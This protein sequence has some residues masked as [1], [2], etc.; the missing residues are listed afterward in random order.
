MIEDPYKNIKYFNLEN[1]MKVYILPDKKATN[2]KI[3]IE[4]K[5]G[6][7]IENKQNAG[8][9]HIVEHLMFRDKN[10]PHEDYLDYIK[11]EGG[12]DVNAY[13]S[14]FKTTYFATIKSN[15]TD[16]LV[17]TF[18][19]MLFIKN[20]R[21]KDLEIEKRALQAE[22]GELEWYD[23]IFYYLSKIEVLFS[24]FDD[25]YK[26][27]F[28][29]EKNKKLP[30]QYF[31][32]RNNYNFTL[33]D[34][35]KYYNEYYYPS[36][37]TLKIVGNFNSQKIQ[38]NIEKLYGSIDK[39]G[40]KTVAEPKGNAK[41]NN[42]PYINYQINSTSKDY[43]YIGA[44]YIQ[45]SYKKYL[46]LEVYS[47]FLAKDLQQKLRNTL[48]ESYSVND[49]NF[50]LR[51]G[52]LVGV[53]FDSLH[54]SFDKNITF[55]KNKISNDVKKIDSLQIIKALK[56]YENKFNVVEHDSKS[57]FKRINTLQNIHKKHEGFKKTPYEIFKSIS[58]TDFQKTV[59]STFKKE[60]EYLFIY[61][62][63]Y[64]FP[65]EQVLIGFIFIFLIIYIF[66]NMSKIQ[67]NKQ[68]LSYTQRD[69]IFTR[70]ISSRF[71]TTVVFILAIFIASLIDEW[72]TH[73][74]NLTLGDINYFNSIDSAFKYVIEIISFLFFI[75]IFIIILKSIFGRYF[76]KLDI[77]K[78]QIN[79]TGNNIIR[80][81][82]E[83]IKSIK[84]VK[85]SI[86]RFFKTIGIS[87]LFF[88]PLVIIETIENKKYYIRS[89]NAKH[90]KEDLQNWK[91]N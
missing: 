57:L 53:S 31:Y 16:W 10:V 3:S 36:N 38:K 65:Y 35:M 75:F 7:D 12:I 47:K 85:W 39:K 80:I 76:A 27:E 51:N 50:G 32:K 20:L 55:I 69:I 14:R 28:S 88:K 41:L 33:E 48:G 46:I 52:H 18:F 19:N 78:N 21:E 68:K 58:L 66:I 45:D 25:F 5:A 6:T 37:M 30:N 22:I 49:F 2:T 71:F 77:T 17:E 86:Y 54:D 84:T 15:K 44:K 62:S 23:K 89:S 73:F 72:T 91:D 74:Y 8:I 87:F 34:I 24:D 79:I 83:E 90:L 26:N 81:E 9:T 4:V 82:K 56:D 70:R 11:E 40:T 13:T 59:S 61:K 42:K 67:L 1:G 60:N 43:G 29:L 64:F 63:Y